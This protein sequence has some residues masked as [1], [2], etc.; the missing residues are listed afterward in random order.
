MQQKNIFFCDLGKKG[1]NRYNSFMKTHIEISSGNLKHNLNLF[2]RLSGKKLMFVVKANAYG[3]GL[4][5]VV[6]QTKAMAAIQYYA[7]DSLNEAL[8]VR[9]V[10]AEKP[11]LIIGWAD[12]GELEEIIRHGFEMIAPSI[13]FLKK[14]SELSAKHRA[15]ARVH[16]KL[17][18]GTSRLGLSPPEL[19]DF[20][21]SDTGEYLQ[22]T[23]LYSHFANIEDTTDHTYAR[24]QLDIFNKTLGQIK[25][26]SL[27]K[28]FSCSASALLFP[29]THFDLVRVGISAYGY[30]PSKQT[31]VSYMEKNKE[32]I[33]LKPALSWYA[34]VAQVKDL[35]K[36]QFI[37]YGLTYQT[38]NKTRMIVVPVG[39]YDGYDR[40]L[41]NIANVLINDSRAPI[42][43]RI[44]MNMFM[45]EVGHID[46]VAQGDQVV[47]I[48]QQGENRLDADTLADLIGSINY[49]VLCRINP[50]IP[51][52]IIP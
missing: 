48:G 31:Y 39:Y 9:S 30:W 20:L 29:E 41:S 8:A 40:K 3:H 24:R 21:E 4:K 33:T 36:G 10:A 44:C 5:E 42:R 51:R 46:Q 1:L 47:L 34:K 49:E 38:F 17:E 23:G 45:A 7:V 11:I 12:E 37:G 19:L 6:E 16:L 13:P 35:E 27:I 28:H 50:M 26:S 22:V 14:I 15:P 2:H 18:T 25:H 43:G 32:R 52:C